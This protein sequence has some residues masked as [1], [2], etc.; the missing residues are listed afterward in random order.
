MNNSKLAVDTAALTEE[1]EIDRLPMLRERARNIEA[2]VGAAKSI[3]DSSQWKVLEAQVFGPEARSL[4][5]RL[6]TEKNPTEF[7]RLQGRIE[8]S[9]KLSLDILVQAKER[10][11]ESLRKQINAA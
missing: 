7:Y 8:E 3:R 6:K 11:L 2:V 10:E 1:P 4:F 9:E 5:A